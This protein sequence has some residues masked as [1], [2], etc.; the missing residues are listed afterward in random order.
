VLGR[1]YTGG[2][3][4]RLATLELT[5]GGLGSFQEGVTLDSVML[6]T[7]ARLGPLLCQTLDSAVNVDYERGVCFGSSV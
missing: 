3:V 4:G 5:D 7:W 2:F 6:F 1:V